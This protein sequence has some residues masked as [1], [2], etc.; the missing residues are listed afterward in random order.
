VFSTA[1][2]AIQKVQSSLE[3]HD[4]LTVSF[5]P[6]RFDLH[7]LSRSPVQSLYDALSDVDASENSSEDLK[8]QLENLESRRSVNPKN[9][10]IGKSFDFTM[11]WPQNPFFESLWMLLAKKAS[12]LRERDLLPAFLKVLVRVKFPFRDALR[13]QHR[14]TAEIC[15]NHPALVTYLA[16]LDCADLIESKLF[17]VLI[18][19]E[20][21]ARI[22]IRYFVSPLATL[23]RKGRIDPSVCILD[24]QWQKD[25]IRVLDG[26]RTHGPE[27]N[28][29]QSTSGDFQRSTFVQAQ[30]GF[31]GWCEAAKIMVNGHLCAR[32]YELSKTVSNLDPIAAIVLEY[33]SLIG[34]TKPSDYYYFA[35]GSKH[36]RRSAVLLLRFRLLL[37]NFVFCS[38]MVLRTEPQT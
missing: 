35:G 5:P 31:A 26:K 32:Q 12:I 27:E 2:N 14:A 15:S 37:I 33:V 36:I 29:L 38:Q 30:R 21:W 10:A 11:L 7:T 1:K 16:T 13:V 18:L 28:E 6:A 4:L 20:N 9:F 25:L 34:N 19:E 22:H 3:E 8:L 23:A 17:P 24:S